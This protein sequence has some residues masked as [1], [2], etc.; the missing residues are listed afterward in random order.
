MPRL[1]FQQIH[2]T[3]EQVLLALG[4]SDERA[5]TAATLFT[6]SS[7]D[8]VLSHGVH[9]FPRFVTM[10][11]N[12]SIDIEAE[13]KRVSPAGMLEQWEGHLGPG[14]LNAL[15]CMDRAIEIAEHHGIGCVALRNTNHWMRG[16][17][18]VQRAA[19]SGLVGIC[20][21]NT[22]QNMPPW[23]GTEAAIGNNP[24]CIG[25]PHG[26]GDVILD[27]AIAQFSYGGLS[28]YAKRKED[29]PVPGGYDEEGKLTTDA[30]SIGKSW[31]T[32]PIGYW[33]GSG[34]SIVLDML[35]AI[36]SGGRSTKDIES[37][38]LKE[39]G[40]S[41]VFIAID[42][43][44]QNSMDWIDQIL[45]DIKKH[46]ASVPTVEGAT[47]PRTPG[48][49]LLKKRAENKERGIPV[50]DDIWELIQGF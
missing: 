4:F 20:W 1:S 37:D 38:P 19:D 43:G 9:R 11:K 10:I 40:L 44:R 14:N 30:E 47:P 41:Q 27:M 17:S 22:N 35:A 36:L 32:L 45:T 26:D 6:K 3:L 23:G 21:T 50:D 42:P 5:D 46:I 34:L 16:G 29:L 18:Y 39:I 25:I 33:K 48:Q 24:L 2:S 7:E 28:A 12:G 15:R 13:A 8:G 49:G 31:R